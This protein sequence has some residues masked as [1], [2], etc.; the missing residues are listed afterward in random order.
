VRKTIRDVVTHVLADLSKSW[1]QLALADLAFKV[2]SFAALTPA[3]LLLL[4]W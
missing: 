1:R 2:I 3:T 4:R